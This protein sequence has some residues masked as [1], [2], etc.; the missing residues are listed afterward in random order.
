ML[1]IRFDSDGDA[2]ERAEY[3]EAG[4]IQHICDDELIVA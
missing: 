3:G 1:Y 4:E 2:D